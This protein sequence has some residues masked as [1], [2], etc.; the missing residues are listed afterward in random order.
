MTT[1][2]ERTLS[3]VRATIHRARMSQLLSD[4]LSLIDVDSVRSQLVAP[5]LGAL[6]WSIE[7]TGEVRTE[8]QLNGAASR[9]GTALFLSGMPCT[10]IESRGLRQEINRKRLMGQVLPGASDAGFEWVLVTDGDIYDVFN[11]QAGLPFENRSFDAIRISDDSMADAVEFFDLFSMKRM[12]ENRL[13]SVWNRRVVDRQVQ[14]S[15]EELIV[16]DEA[17]IQLLLSKTRELSASD[18][19]SSL[20]RAKIVLE[21]E[22]RERSQCRC[23]VEFDRKIGRASEMSEAELRVATWL[24]RRSIERW[25][26]GGAT[27]ARSRTLQ[28]RGQDHRRSN[29]ERRSSDQDRR[30]A[31]VENVTERRGNGERRS[32]ERRRDFERRV[33][34]DR[35]RERRRA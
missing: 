29:A 1:V 17:L 11:A 24:Q 10:W 30:V 8:F 2:L 28:R 5:I 19:R 33:K 32:D 35:R 9:S 3:Q 4:R 6:G 31:R 13:E 26:K 25:A 18:I 7:D 14:R 22:S 15:F 12:E 21:F 23:S 16:S 27:V 20:S 34:A